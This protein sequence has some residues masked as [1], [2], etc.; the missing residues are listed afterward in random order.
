MLSSGTILQGRY[1]IQG[2]LGRGGMG[3]VYL[4]Q[5]MR[6]G[7]RPVAVKEMIP[8]PSASSAEQAQAQRQ[9]QR[10][11]SMLASLNH[12]NVPRVSD[13]FSEMGKHYLVMDYVDGE[14]LEDILNRTPGFLPES[15]VLHWATQLCDVLTYLH[16]RQP[17]VVFR[18]LKP[19]NVMVDRSG[20]V[21]LIDFGIARVFKPGKTTDTLR[22]GTMGYAPPEQYAGKGQ[23]DVRSD[24]Y[25]L[26]ATLHHLLTR[27]DPTQYPP[28]TF[29]TAPPRSMNSAVSPHVEAATMK[30]LAHDRTQRFQTAAEMKGAL[31]GKAPP[32]PPT[33][34]PTAPLVQRTTPF[35]LVAAVVLLIGVTCVIAGVL[36]TFLRPALTPAATVVRPT[37]T[38][39]PRIATPV[40]PTPTP[41]IVV[42]TATP[43]PATNTPIPPM[44]TPV[45]PTPT[46]V[47]VVVTATPRPATHTPIP[48][49]PTPVPPSPTP[50]LTRAEREARVASRLRLRQGNGD[51]IFAYRTEQPPYIDGHLDE[52]RDKS[53]SIQHPVFKAENWQG[54]WDL[55]G[56]F[57]VTWDTDHLYVGV[58]VTD[59]QCVQNESGRM[60]YKGDDVEIQ[61]DAELEA[62]FA[63]DELSDDDNQIGLSAGNFHDRSPEAYVWLPSERSGT[64][65]EMAARQTTNGY[66]LEAAIP[67][68]VLGVQPQPERAYGFALSLSDNDTPGTSE[69]ECMVSTS[70]NRTTYSNPTL[71]GNLILMDLE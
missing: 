15:Q 63:L 4:A 18:D 3:A 54:W 48:P 13:H 21:K 65:I 20:T 67:W 34:K 68:W 47:V 23:T 71:L 27:R 33:P 5:D 42:I 30:A 25:S 46:P 59:D 52:W 12:S 10:E 56:I 60:M 19:V 26:G 17:P 64:M 36:F 69:Q 29:N 16:S 6:L 9:F 31:L 53:Y 57:F 22:M 50:T 11:A 38:V 7:N 39:T 2:T 55:S 37:A 8:D 24:I 1:N 62:D 14:T 45:P 41:V 40:P 43:V 44:P 51:V 70:P 32:S 61:F 35:L 58:E 49:T 66:V 28:F